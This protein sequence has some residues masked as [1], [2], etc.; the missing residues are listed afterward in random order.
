MLYRA[1]SCE[2]A[3]IDPT[4]PMQ[5]TM[6]DRTASNDSPAAPAN[7]ATAAPRILVVDDED[8]ICRLYEV[9]LNFA[10]YETQSAADGGQALGMLEA[11]D[12]DLVLTDCNMPH[13][14]GCDLIRS[15]RA[16]GNFVPVMMSSGSIETREHLP[17]DLRG[18]VAVIL[19]KWAKAEE[20]LHGVAR[21]LAGHPRSLPR[22]EGHL[23]QEAAT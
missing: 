19:P 1:P 11:G 20:L 3:F 18:E 17:A 8:F 15:L 10:G 14:S 2:H 4:H 5:P 7:E 16:R 22:L 6:R 9:V 23:S 12:F 13:L 21:A